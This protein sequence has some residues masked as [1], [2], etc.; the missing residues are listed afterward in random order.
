[1]DVFSRE[2]T[3]ALDPENGIEEEYM[4]YHNPVYNWRLLR[5]L[6]MQNTVDYCNLSGKI[7]PLYST[8][9]YCQLHQL[10]RKGL[11]S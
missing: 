11:K 2:L 4:P 7:P 10:R 9:A 8:D 3:E 6:L 5:L 1:M